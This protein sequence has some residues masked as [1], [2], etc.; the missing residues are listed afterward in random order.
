M[1]NN[2]TGAKHI[3]QLVHHEHI[4]PHQTSHQVSWLHPRS[5]RWYQLDLVVTRQASINNV[6]LTRSLHSTDCNN[7]HSLICSKVKLRAKEIHHSKQK[8][9]PHINTAKMSVPPS[10]HRNLLTPSRSQ[11]T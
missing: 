6:L 5:H 4:L 8:G 1:D 2:Y 10:C 9:C 7:H 11:H 3:P